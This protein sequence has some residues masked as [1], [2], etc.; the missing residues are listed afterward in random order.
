[1][2][3]EIEIVNKAL[4]RLGAKPVTS[5]NGLISGITETSLQSELAVNSYAILRDAV[6]EDRP[7]TIAMN[8]VILNADASPP[9]FGYDQRFPVPSDCINVFRCDDGS[10]TY[11]I[12]WVREG[13]FVFADNTS[14]LYM[15][16][17]ARLTDT[18]Q[19]SNMFINCLSLRLAQEWCLA[20]TESNGLAQSL[21][22]EYQA[23]LI[24]ASSSDGSQSRRELFRSRNLT[25]ARNGGAPF[26]NL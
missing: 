5:T 24:Q 1:M 18:N 17:I 14:T 23:M 2:T 12:K 26:M 13:A 7:W 25:A 10:G 15:E 16:Y 11:V 9:A 20:I 22:Q 21:M 4:Y 6:L 8:R 19:Y 3:T